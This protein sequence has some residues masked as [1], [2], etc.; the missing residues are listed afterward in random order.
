MNTHNLTRKLADLPETFPQDPPRSAT[1]ITD[2]FRHADQVRSI[3]KEFLGDKDSFDR[4]LDTV[5]NI[6]DASN[7]NLAY[8]V[9]NMVPGND[10]RSAKIE[11]FRNAMQRFESQNTKPA[12]LILQDAW[13]DYTAAYHM[14]IDAQTEEADIAATEIRI[15]G[16]LYATIL[17]A[18][19]D[20]PDTAMMHDDKRCNVL[21]N[22]SKIIRQRQERL[23]SQE[24]ASIAMMGSHS[25]IK[26]SVAAHIKI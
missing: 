13:N 17:K 16:Y 5:Q 14:T 15:F 24:G 1:A 11:R 25:K 4:M 26:K 8:R 18:G 10:V 2:P 3:I 12:R 9:V 21:D 22:L 20:D 23:A 19:Q 6:I 7:Q